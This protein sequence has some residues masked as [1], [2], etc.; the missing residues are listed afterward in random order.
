MYFTALQPHTC[1]S[2]CLRRGEADARMIRRPRIMFSAGRSSG[3]GGLG[4][5]GLGAG[6][7]VCDTS[8]YDG[9]G[10]RGIFS[11]AILFGGY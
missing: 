4:P 8:S 7:L 1:A 5:F 2:N 11:S 9:G 6:A 10:A 3:M